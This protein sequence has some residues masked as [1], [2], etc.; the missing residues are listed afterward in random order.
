M[1]VCGFFLLATVRLMF[2]LLNNVL[3]ISHK[4]E[5]IKGKNAAV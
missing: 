5:D 4:T 1:K 2:L 3:K